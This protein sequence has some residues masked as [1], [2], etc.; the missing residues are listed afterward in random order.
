MK[1]YIKSYTELYPISNNDI[2]E[3]TYDDLYLFWCDCYSA[4]NNAAFGHYISKYDIPNCVVPL[5]T[6]TQLNPG[7]ILLGYDSSF[8]CYRMFKCDNRSP[9]DKCFDGTGTGYK[10]TKHLVIKR[11]E[12]FYSPVY[13]LDER[14]R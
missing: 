3:L 1:R 6:V 13:I 11:K 4:R 7:D 12:T 2:E 10:I 8:K 5:E 14:S 9:Y